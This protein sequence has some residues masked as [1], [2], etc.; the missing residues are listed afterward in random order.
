M[1]RHF[2][3]V[4]LIFILPFL[5]LFPSANAEKREWRLMGKTDNG[6]FLLYIDTKSISYESGNIFKIRAKKELTREAFNEAVE[7]AEKESGAKVEDPDDLFKIIVKSE[8]REYEYQIDCEKNELKNIPL[9][10][11]AVNII[12]VFPILPNSAEENIKK[13]FCLPR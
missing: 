11:S 13:E 3:I 6:K 8:I 4:L 1:A 12:T 10:T 5:L 2:I 7:R 9:K